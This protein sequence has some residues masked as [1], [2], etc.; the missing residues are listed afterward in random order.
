MPSVNCNL[1]CHIQWLALGGLPSSEGKGGGVDLGE[2]GGCVGKGLGGEEG[3][4]CGRD[5]KYGKN[6][7]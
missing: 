4:N 1:I 3:H 5:V 2:K 6:K 7:N